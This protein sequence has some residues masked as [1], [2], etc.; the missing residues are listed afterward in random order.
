MKTKDGQLNVIETQNRVEQVSGN[1]EKITLTEQDYQRLK[2]T[3][4]RRK[5]YWYRIKNK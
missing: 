3:K 5:K 4:R 2:E 1:E